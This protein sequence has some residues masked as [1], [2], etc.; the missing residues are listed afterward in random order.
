MVVPHP[1][2]VF[3][4]MSGRR[5]VAFAGHVLFETRRDDGVKQ[6][7]LVT[8]V[9]IE[10]GSGNPC[11]LGDLAGGNCRAPGVGQQF[12]GCTQQPNFGR[13]LA[14]ET[15]NRYPSTYSNAI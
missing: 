13:K 14:I 3:Q 10:G 6:P 7:F 1:P 12:G 5:E 2:D 4:R 11:Q 15:H 8:E 9:V